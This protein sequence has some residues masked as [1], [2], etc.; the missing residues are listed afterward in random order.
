MIL[1]VAATEIEMTPFLEQAESIQNC[2]SCVSGVG[3]VE[4]A[5]RLTS[6]LDNHCSEKEIKA[7]VNFGVAGA[8]PGAKNRQ[9]AD[10]LDCCLAEYEILGDL[11]ICFDDHLQALPAELGVKNRFRLDV[12]LDGSH[13]QFYYCKLYKRYCKT[14]GDPAK[15]LSGAV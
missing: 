1:A 2:L 5:V 10:L 8:Y 11:G 6:F 15:E 14:G 13:R 3:P 4:T 7:V 12:E 9:Q